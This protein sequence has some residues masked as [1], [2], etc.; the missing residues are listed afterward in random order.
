MSQGHSATLQVIT[1]NTTRLGMCL[2]KENPGEKILKIIVKIEKGR[3]SI[4]R[5][6]IFV[7]IFYQFG[8]GSFSKK[9]ER[10]GRRG[11][12]EQYKREDMRTKQ[13]EGEI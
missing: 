12:Q 3:R 7:V 8:L 6:I 4:Q 9:T 11:L 13:R 10:R 2:T 5:E 1:M